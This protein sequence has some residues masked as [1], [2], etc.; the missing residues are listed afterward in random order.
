MSA[1]K[2]FKIFGV[3]N[4]KIGFL[5]T[6]GLFCSFGIANFFFNKLYE[7]LHTTQQVIE[8]T[9][10]PVQ[11]AHQQSKKYNKNRILELKCSS[12]RDPPHQ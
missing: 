8:N 2:H 3:T 11:P 4:L 5:L 12:Q 6:G 1:A 9:H 7:E 10:H